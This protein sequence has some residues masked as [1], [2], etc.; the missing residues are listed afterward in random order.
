M[1]IAIVANQAEGGRMAFSL[2]E[3]KLQEGLKTLGLATGSSPLA[4]Y[5]TLAHSELDFSQVTTIN[6]DEYVGLSADNPQS[7]HYFMQEH[8]FQYKTFAANYLPDGQAQDLTRAAQAY[9]QV[10]TEHPIDLQLLGIGRNGHI[11]FNE[12]GTAFDSQTHLVDLTASTIAA[13]SRF[14]TTEEEVP[15][16]A[17]SMGIASIMQA[18]SI[19]LFAYGPE[20]AQ[21]IKQMVTGPVTEAMPASILQKHADV[22][23][24]LDASAASA[25]P[26]E[27]R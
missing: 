17:I 8:L 27:T 2:I 22:Q 25:L 11:G 6:L 20:K 24:I 16:Q 10:M 23:L 21:A 15:K 4:L 19:I 7:Y 1:K 18:K 3:K 9:D 14:F 13:N 12:P 26:S 5:D